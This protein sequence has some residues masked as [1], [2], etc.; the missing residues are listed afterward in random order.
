MATTRLTYDIYS[1]SGALC[2]DR[3]SEFSE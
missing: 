3:V 2:Q 1:L